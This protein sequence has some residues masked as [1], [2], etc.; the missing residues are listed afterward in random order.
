MA[1]ASA[2]PL[3]ENPPCPPFA[4]GGTP[5][6]TVINEGTGT[7]GSTFISEG[8]G[9]QGAAFINEGTVITGG[10]RLHRG[11]KVSTSGAPLI[12]VITV[13]F[14]GVKELPATIDSVTAQNYP[15]I[16]YVIV[17]G[18]SKDGTVDLLRARDGE[19]DFWVSER[20]SGVYDA[21][22]KAIDHATGEWI[23]FL[24]AGDVLVNSFHEIA[25]RLQDPATVYYGDV[26]L[27]SRHMIYNG[28]YT[29]HKLSRF[30][31]PHQAMFYPKALFEHHRFDL[32]YRIMADYVC[33]IRA[34]CDRRYSFR[35]LRTLVTIYEDREGLSSR[36]R[37]DAF[38][39]DIAGIIRE[40]F[41]PL[42]GCEYLVRD[43]FRSFERKVLRKIAAPF[44]RKNRM[45][46]KRG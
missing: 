46:E 17:D 24:G 40:N 28:K 45:K 1:D 43:F 31:L 4:K 30:N 18:A 26:Y 29:A 6:S 37:D 25:P 11:P 16:E 38:D 35:Y 22:N 10:T 39:R 5:G 36:M 42:F 3:K 12:S 7:A 34:W 33:N 13:V 32:K 44:K 27:P 8:T 9:T 15:N 21:M 41:G 23:I 20:D 14:N 19:I 2:A